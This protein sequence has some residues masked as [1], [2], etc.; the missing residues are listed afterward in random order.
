MDRLIC[1]FRDAE[2][3]TKSNHAKLISAVEFF[4]PETKG[5][6]KISKEAIRGRDMAE[7]V[8]HT[9]PSTTRIVFLFGAA[10]AARGR[11]R[12]TGHAPSGAGAS[13]GSSKGKCSGKRRSKSR[14]RQA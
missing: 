11:A 5:F 9:V 4:I 12:R 14:S 13:K 10:A 2:N 7:P 8:R 6:L 1:D 3:L